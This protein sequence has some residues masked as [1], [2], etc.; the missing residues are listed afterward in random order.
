ML[1]GSIYAHEALIRGPKGMPLHSPDA[2]LAAA[3]KEG[4]LLDFEVACVGAA[5]KRWSNL[6]QPGR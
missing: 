3:R 2:L 4:L 1:D 6:H 5:L